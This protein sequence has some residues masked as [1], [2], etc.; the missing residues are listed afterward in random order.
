MVARCSDVSYQCQ[1]IPKAFD[2]SCAV[3]LAMETFY[4]FLLRVLHHLNGFEGTQLL[5]LLIVIKD[6]FA[7]LLSS[8]SFLLAADSPFH[9]GSPLDTIDSN[10]RQGIESIGPTH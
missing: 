10:V 1:I 6:Y 3:N 7:H 4:S 9:S 8:A 2:W 5:V